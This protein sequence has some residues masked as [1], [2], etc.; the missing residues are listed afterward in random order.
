[1]REGFT[2]LDHAFGA[3]NNRLNEACFLAALADD[4]ETAKALFDRIG[5][6]ADLSVW[7]YQANFNGYRAWANLKQIKRQG[8]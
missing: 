8:S 2:E 6:D 1:M 7:K 5:E 4:R 3:S